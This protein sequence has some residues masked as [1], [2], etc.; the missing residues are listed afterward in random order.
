MA[1]LHLVQ[2]PHPLFFRVLPNT[3]ACEG[4]PGH[5]SPG[6]LRDPPFSRLPGFLRA[7]LVSTMGISWLPGG[8][9]CVEPSGRRA[10]PRLSHT[11]PFTLYG[12]PVIGPLGTRS[13]SPAFA[14]VGVQS[15]RATARRAHRAP[16]LSLPGSCQRLEGFGGGLAADA[17]GVSLA[18][19]S[20][21]E[22]VCARAQKTSGEAPQHRQAGRLLTASLHSLESIGGC[23]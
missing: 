18:C 23:P 8:R 13:V 21:L 3:A 22:H 6:P 5:R 4:R 9:Q 11:Q 16:G 1:S 17:A 15:G 20:L 10:G 12:V 7:A 19:H 14:H 2:A